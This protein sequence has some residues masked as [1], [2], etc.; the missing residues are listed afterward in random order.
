MV[1]FVTRRGL[2]NFPVH[3]NPIDNIVICDSAAGIP[4]T[5]R[6]LKSPV[7]LRKPLVI[8]DIDITA[9]TGIQPYTTK[10]NTFP[11]GWNPRNFSRRFR[12]FFD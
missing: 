8:Y 7:K 11:T 6:T 3:F 9:N 12:G 10:V 2:H 1:T 4:A 5:K